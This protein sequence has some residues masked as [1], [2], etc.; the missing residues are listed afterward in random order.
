MIDAVLPVQSQRALVTEAVPCGSGL[1]SF[2][3]M[4]ARARAESRALEE[5]ARVQSQSQSIANANASGVSSAA[6]APR[7]RLRL[8]RLASSSRQAQSKSLSAAPASSSPSSS[9][10]RGVLDKGRAGKRDE[11]REGQCGQRRAALKEDEGK[12]GTKARRRLW[13]DGDGETKSGREEEEEKRNTATWETSLSV[14][15]SQPSS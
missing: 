8:H 12:P 13:D 3:V 2:G 11:E 9:T 10:E 5:A 15:E 1:F 14:E 4:V 6:S 7:P